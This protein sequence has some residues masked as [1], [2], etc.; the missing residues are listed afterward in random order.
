V[1]IDTLGR[2]NIISDDPLEILMMIANSIEKVDVYP[3]TKMQ[4]LAKLPEKINQFK[5][6]KRNH[7]IG[8]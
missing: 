5:V 2:I 6:T 8:R 1:E 4:N 7:L 3:Q